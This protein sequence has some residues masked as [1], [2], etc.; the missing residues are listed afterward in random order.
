MK[1]T[2]DI[3]KCMLAFRL[4]RKRNNIINPKGDF[5]KT[6]TLALC[7][8]FCAASAHA[9]TTVTLNLVDAKG[10]VAGIGQ[11]SI[12]ETKY[13]LVFTPALKGLPPGL[14]GF[15]LHQ[16]PSCP[17]PGEGW[18]HGT[19]HGGGWSLRPYQFQ[20]PRHTLG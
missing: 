18:R 14:H 11:V 8:L 4:S 3:L 20:A 2:G 13:G 5:M 17:P 10:I 6:I 7:I 12:T 15:H 16:N 1:K 9:E 19:R